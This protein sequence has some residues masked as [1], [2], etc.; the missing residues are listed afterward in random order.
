MRPFCCFLLFVFLTA[1]AADDG[2]IPGYRDLDLLQYDLPFTVQAPDSVAVRSSS[3]SGV[4]TDVTLVSP[5]DNYAVQV[6]ASQATTNDMARLKAEQ[7]EL[8]RGNR[9]FERIVAETTDGFLFENRI[10][11]L[12]TFGFRHIVYQGNREFVFQNA[13]SGTFT[14][15]EARRMYRAV[16][17]R[18]E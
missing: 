1:C 4:M 17:G 9:Y 18:L 13:L 16:G 11:T 3:L 14:E 12:A 8:V 10:D 6:L 7:L 5:E 2:G 15:Q